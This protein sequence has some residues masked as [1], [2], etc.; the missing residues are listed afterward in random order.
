MQG[1]VFF[2]LVYTHWVDYDKPHLTYDEQLRKL[3][4][5][6]LSYQNHAVAIAALK[7]IGYYRLS[8]Y[9]YPFRKREGARP[10]DDYIDGTTMEA[11]TALHDF[12]A[13]L[14]SL[15]LVGLEKFEV[16]LRVQVA[17]VL[18]ARDRYGHIEKASLDARRCDNV[19][20]NA[21][22]GQ[23]DYELWL[24][25]YA[26]WCDDSRSEDFVQH[27]HE[28]YDGRLP[29]W[30]AT[31]VMDLGG[32]VRLYGFL[33]RADR[34]VIA[35]HFGLQ[36]D[37]DFR[38]WLLGLNLLRNHCAHG[39]RIWNRRLVYTL[40]TIQPD[41]VGAEVRHLH[42]LDDEGRKKIYAFATILASLVIKADPYSNW[43]RTFATLVKK[44]PAVPGV[45]SRT[46]MGFV[47]GWD[48]Q[49]IWRYEP[50]R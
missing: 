41:T 38:S 40:A 22:G 32:L 10:V 29:I 50:R 18:G 42:E 11:V 7:R 36:R 12:D 33:I 30:V 20:P 1:S 9:T 37:S 47:D 24:K 15:L 19:R 44:F 21:P 4:S 43:P 25:K 28:K 45:A 5:R 6:G 16:A 13:K 26:K 27:F 17:Y 48:T 46:T 14:R 34:L 2:C 31:E 39:G 23:S 49:D 8:A 3:V 35:R